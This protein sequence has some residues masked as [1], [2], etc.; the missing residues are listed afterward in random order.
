MAEANSQDQ[1]SDDGYWKSLLSQSGEQTPP[2]SS[3]APPLLGER[4]G[5]GVDGWALAEKSHATGET[6]ELRVIGYNRGGVL[7]DLGNVH[8]FV[9]ASQLSSFSRK[10]NEE[11]RTQELARQVGQT[12]KLKTIELDRARNRLIL[13]ERAVNPPVSRADQVLA[14]LAPQQTREG[15]I[16]NVTD[17]GAFVDLGG[18]EGLIHVSE[19]SWHHVGHP[20]E[21]LSPGEK[22]QVLIMDINR[23][24]KRISCSLKRLT[25]NPWMQLAEKFKPGDW[26]DGVVT[27][28]VAFGA[29]VSILDGVE[30]LVHVSEMAE[31]N[32]LHPRD[33][34]KEGQPVRARIMSIEPEQQR[35]GLSLRA[36]HAAKDI[37]LNRSAEEAPPPPDADYWNSIAQSEV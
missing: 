21:M 1:S 3:P 29:F 7:V 26:I 8:G 31:G 28:V 5:G 34:V 20:R 35:V 18:V 14:T 11:E 32:F 25:P 22:V 4:E 37:A 2:T 33:V 16:R 19:L 10:A 23:E 15:M 27:N 13:S 17:F 36:V 30:G 24:S 12:L 6:L 9:P